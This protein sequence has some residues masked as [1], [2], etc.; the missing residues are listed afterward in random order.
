MNADGPSTNNDGG[1]RRRLT[2][3]REGRVLTGV[4]GG[5]ADYFGI[6]PIWIRGA[7]VLIVVAGGGL[8]G[9]GLVA[10][11][12]LS[13]V[14]PAPEAPNA[15]PR[16]TVRRGADDMAQRLREGLRRA[17]GDDDR[18]RSTLGLLLLALGA[19]FLLE[20]LGAFAWLHAGVVWPLLLIAAG[21]WLLSQGG[22]WR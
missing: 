4:C 8:G 22:F 12:L 3:R 1:S 17:Q 19:L 20:G 16:E 6:E 10:Y 11:L 13:L 2:R 5:I 15:D 14:I 21:A 7:F 18:T 9:G